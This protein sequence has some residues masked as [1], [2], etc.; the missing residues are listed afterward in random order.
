M[1]WRSATWAVTEVAHHF[2]DFSTT[3]QQQNHGE[4]QPMNGAELSHSTT[5]A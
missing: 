4:D 3:E 5:P 1:R 2:R